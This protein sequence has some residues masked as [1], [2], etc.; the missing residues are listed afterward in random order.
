MPIL[1]LIQGRPH[2]LGGGMTV[3]RLLPAA[4]QQA[5]GPFIFFDHFGPVSVRPQDHHVAP[6]GACT[7][8]A[9]PSTSGRT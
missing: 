8:K 9:S 5:I 4:G 7:R 6:C 1:K 3:K 2:D